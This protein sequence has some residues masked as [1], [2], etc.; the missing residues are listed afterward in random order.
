MD[1]NFIDKLRNEAIHKD[2]TVNTLVSQ[3]IKCHIDWHSNASKAGFISVR[4]GFL[5][6]LME[7]LS[8]QDISDISKNMAK[9]ET[10]SFV[11]LLR[12]KYDIG[13]SVDVIDNWIKISGYSYRHENSADTHSYVIQH[14][15]GRKMSLY[16]AEVYRYL[17]QE[18]NIRKVTF[19]LNDNTLSF[20][21]D[22]QSS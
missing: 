18:F 10:K 6:K 9:N 14:D 7:K 8:E 22:I 15:M 16:L 1:K 4:R 11:L 21:V 12:N 13:S 20:V 2:I 5:I 3:I 19:D 17:F